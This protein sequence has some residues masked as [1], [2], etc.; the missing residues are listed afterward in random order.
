MINFSFIGEIEY[1]TII[2]LS[3]DLYLRYLNGT[4]RCTNR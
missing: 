2:G 4:E 1:T 3:D